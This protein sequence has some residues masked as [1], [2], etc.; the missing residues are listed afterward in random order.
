ML[1]Y[2]NRIHLESPARRGKWGWMLVTASVPFFWMEGH[3]G[4]PR[5]ISLVVGVNLVF[6]GLRLVYWGEGGIERRRTLREQ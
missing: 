2:V 1:T 4:N 3:A 6:A 5:V